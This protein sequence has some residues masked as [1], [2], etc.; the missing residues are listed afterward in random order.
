[1]DRK[2]IFKNNSKSIIKMD[3]MNMM[4]F[5]DFQNCKDFN[6]KID[7]FT[8]QNRKEV[9]SLLLTSKDSK[10]YIFEWL[11]FKTKVKPYYDID[12]F[13][14]SQEEQ[15]SNTEIIKEQVLETLKKHYPESTIAISSS[16]G[17][18]TKSKTVKKVRK[19]IK[20]FATSFHFVVSD[21]ECSV[22]ELRE[23]NEKN[24]LYD[25]KIDGTNEKLFDKAVYRDGGNMR[26]LYSYKPNDPRQKIPE[27]Y[28]DSYMITKHIIQSTPETNHFKRTLPNA[29][30]PSS[31]PISPKVKVKVEEVIEEEVIEEDLPP[32]VPIKEYNIQDVADCLKY[33]DNEDCF[34]YETWIKIGMAIHNITDGDMV[35]LGLY[36]DFSKKDEDNYDN[37]LIRKNWKY[38]DKSKNN[39][40]NKVGM[41]TLKKLA[42]KYKPIDVKTSCEH[43]FKRFVQQQ[44]DKNVDFMGEDIKY[45][46]FFKSA[47]KKVLQFLNTKL[48]FVRETGDYIIL[49]SQQIKKENEETITKPSWYLKTP[50]KAKDHFKKENFKAIFE[51]ESYKMNPFEA[52]CNW[53][54]R[55]EVRAIG[56]DPS[57]KPCDDIFNLWNGFNISKEEADEYNEEDAEPILEHMKELWC[58]DDETSF[59]YV[60]DL[61]AHYIQKPHI[62]T[63]VLLALKSKQGGGKGIILNKLAEIIGD[64][65]YV[66][67]SNADYL[68][69][70]FNGQLEGKI[71]CNLDE[72]FWGGDKKMEGMVKNK[73]T[74]K[75]QT[76]NKKNKEAYSIDDY[77]NYII[78]TNN[79]WFSGVSADDRR[80]YCLQ[81]SDFLCGRMTEEKMKIV[82]PVLDAPAEAF[83][84]VL[85]NRDI[86]EFNPRIFNKTKLLQD[87]VER[88]W[89]SVKTWFHMALK[90]GGMYHPRYGFAEW[91][92]LW[93]EKESGYGRLK[94]GV[95]MKNKKTKE[96]EV[97]YFKEYIFE[98]YNST[99]SDNR[100]FGNEAF[101]KEFK[102]NCL[103]DIYME[104]RVQIKKER[105]VFVVLPTL[106]KARENW[107]KVQEFKYIYGDVD[108]D[109]DIEGEYF[110]DDEDDN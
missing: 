37:E 30:P 94:G 93:V 110:S 107:N 6:I 60:M 104:R 98:C 92:E 57:S 97:A 70:N 95:K 31:P 90:D 13:Y 100:K 108:D 73:I 19:E 46:M 51:D 85:Y 54:D 86:S 99:S 67:N 83:A 34:E 41:T 87:Q 68:F 48:I 27:N 103:K 5:K 47:E 80:H 74:E 18:K 7:P 35:G 10:K 44:Y 3:V 14:E 8:K 58:N 69:G 84:K 28:K 40:K 11:D 76:I 71:V 32:F 91:G 101:F 36:I 64:D 22:E 109:W 106:D 26:F 25:L 49:D 89:N 16:H 75:R 50:T 53:I 29:S 43:I 82:Q 105:R 9:E 4:R 72:A 96:K 59:N 23:F 38:W 77:V 65:H 45:E 52:W 63:G 39:G 21:Y 1:M 17:A 79:D 2:K 20:G 12:M 78:T 42:N 56:F 55:R 81:L 102:L 33:L 62:K 24:K 66:Q 61:F 15:E 88:N